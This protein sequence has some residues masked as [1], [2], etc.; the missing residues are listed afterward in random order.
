VG[1]VHYQVLRNGTVVATVAGTTYTDATVAAATTYTYVIKAYDEVNNSAMSG[2][3]SVT[4]PASGSVVSDGF[5]TG[6]LTVWSTVNGLTVGTGLVHAGTYA[7]RESSIGATTYAYRTLPATY[8]ELWAQSWVC[9]ASRS[10]SANL[11]GY[12]SSSGASIVNLYLD[13][14]GRVALRNNIGGVTTYSTTTV[15]G[16]AWHRFVLHVLV[17]GTSSSVDVTL[18]GVTVPGLTLTGQDFG[19]NMISKLQLGET[20][21]GRTYDIAFDDIAVAQAPL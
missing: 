11:F 10:T 14:T 19:T 6:N 15:T 21:A 1:L 17:N 3:L 4:T 20:T 5:E 8:G 13:T 18:D 9:V 7:A 2:A 12:R 16:S